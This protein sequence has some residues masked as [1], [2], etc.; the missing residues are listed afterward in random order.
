[1]LKLS[2]SLELVH[3][4][5]LAFFDVPHFKDQSVTDIVASSTIH[6]CEF[7]NS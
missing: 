2:R 7:I 3:Q 1:M 6:D 4:T 5:M